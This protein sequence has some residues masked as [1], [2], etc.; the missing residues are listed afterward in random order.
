MHVH[1]LKVMFT[2]NITPPRSYV[3]IPSPLPSL[4]LLLCWCRWP[5]QCRGV[6][7]KKREPPAAGD[8]AV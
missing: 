7:P 1:V 5:T 6:F 2:I 3:L 8:G 4:S